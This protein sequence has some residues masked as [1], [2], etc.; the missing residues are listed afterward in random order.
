MG[1][2]I[3]GISTMPLAERMRAD[4]PVTLVWYADD[5][6][7]VG[8]AADTARGLKFL[9]EE[10]PKYGYHPEPAKC[11]Y[12]CKAED[13]ACA[14]E[15]FERL[16]LHIQYSRGEQDLGGFVGSAKEQGKG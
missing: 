14:Q 7:A 1:L 13:E 8:K 9:Q 15:E 16:G 11:I 3:Y 12:V 6:G 10:G 2:T 5:S 4:M